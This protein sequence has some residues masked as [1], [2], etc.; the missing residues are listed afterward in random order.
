[1]GSLRISKI[2][3]LQICRAYMLRQSTESKVVLPIFRQYFTLR[4]K[5]GIDICRKQYPHKTRLRGNSPKVSGRNVGF[6]YC[7]SICEFFARCQLY[8]ALSRC[9]DR[10]DILLY[11]P[12]FEVPGSVFTVNIA[13]RD[14]LWEFGIT[15]NTRPRKNQ[16]R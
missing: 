10:I 9:R 6:L 8:V 2:I 16:G 3:V 15:A 12:R 4:S 13:W 14:A 1:M 5:T 11:G 7:G